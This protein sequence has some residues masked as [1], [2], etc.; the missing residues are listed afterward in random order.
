MAHGFS[1]LSIQGYRRL[2]DLNIA[3]RP[4]NVLVGANGVGKSSVLDAL[5]LLAASADRRLSATVSDLGGM[6]SML[7]AD[8]STDTV[9]LGVQADF[10]LPAELDYRLDIRNMMPS[11]AMLSEWLSDVAAVGEPANR[12]IVAKGPDVE[13]IR[14]GQPSGPEG[15]WN[16]GETALSQAPRSHREAMMFQRRLASV[17]DVFHTLD[18]SRRAPVRTPQTI[19]P[20]QGPGINGEDL[21][22]CLYTMRE[23]EHNR[24]EAVEDALRAAFPAFERL[25]FPPVAAGRLLLSW[26]DRNFTRPF[27]TSEL[28]EGTLRFLWLATL[29]QSPGLPEV[30]LIDEP[31]VSLHPELLRL[32]VELMREASTRTQLVVA[33]HSDRLVRFLDPSELLVCDY[34]ETGGMTAKWAD[35]LDLADWLADYTLDQ[36]WS[37]GVLGGR[38]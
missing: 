7:T 30:T 35:T 37:K 36:L 26:R 32:L 1:R 17:S 5:R 27:D 16:S 20:A 22:S 13:F 2:K 4:I 19:S 31:E 38:S 8:G 10:D 9:R 6:W 12:Y 29:L 34:D 14:S 24:Y 25:D 18:V 33:T 28:S 3:L 23:T 11:I 15:A 21:V